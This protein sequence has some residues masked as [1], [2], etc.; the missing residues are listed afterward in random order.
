L[1]NFSLELFIHVSIDFQFRVIVFVYILLFFSILHFIL[2]FSIFN[3]CNYLECACFNRF[4]V[5]LIF[6]EFWLNPFDLVFFI[7]ALKHQNLNYI[8]DLLTAIFI[9]KSLQALF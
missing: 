1:H 3:L 4:E 7:V 5:L 9:F 2:L 6:N 8:F